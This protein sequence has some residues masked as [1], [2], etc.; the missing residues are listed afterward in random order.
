[1][2]ALSLDAARWAAAA[3]ALHPHEWR[4]PPARRLV[5]FL[6]QQQQQRHDANEQTGWSKRVKCSGGGRRWPEWAVIMAARSYFR[7]G[8]PLFL[9]APAA[10]G[11]E[12]KMPAERELQMDSEHLFVQ[13]DKRAL[14]WM[15]NDLLTLFCLVRSSAPPS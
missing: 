3:A 14:D 1:V 9:V 13:L 2:D 6:Q 7:A 15:A 4:R 5:K 11:R 10:G 12:S 8:S